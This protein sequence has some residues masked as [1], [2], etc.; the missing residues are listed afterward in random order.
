MNLL[1]AF[2]V[3]QVVRSLPSAQALLFL[4]DDLPKIGASVSRTDVSGN[5]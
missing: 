4:L 1:V 2:F 3:L 5:C